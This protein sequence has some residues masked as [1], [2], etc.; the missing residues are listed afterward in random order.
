[1]VQRHEI[2]FEQLVELLSEASDQDY[3]LIHDSTD[4]L[5]K[6]IKVGL[7]RSRSTAP[8]GN[9]WH[10]GTTPPANPSE[11]DGWWRSNDDELLVWTGTT[12]KLIDE[13][14]RAGLA[15]V[16]T[17]D[18]VRQLLEAALDI[19][20]L[21]ISTG[22]VFR[23]TIAAQAT[24]TGPLL[25]LVTGDIDETIDGVRHQYTAP[26]ILYVPPLSTR[27]NTLF[28]REQLAA[29]V[30]AFVSQSGGEPADGSVTEAKLAQAVRDKLDHDIGLKPKNYYLGDV[31]DN[32]PFRV[33]QV[34]GTPGIVGTADLDG[35]YQLVLKNPSTMLTGAI[36]GAPERIDEL[37]IFITN[38]GISQR[39]HAVDPYTYSADTQVIDFNISDA[40][41]SSVVASITEPYV[42]FRISYYLSNGAV[43]TPATYRMPIEPQLETNTALVRR[44]QTGG[45]AGG[46]TFGS[47]SGEVATWAE[48]D[49]TANVPDSKISTAI[50]RKTAVDAVQV[51]A[52]TVIEIGPEF[53]HN[54]AGPRNLD[55]SIRH[56]LNAYRTANLMTVSVDGQPAVIV[57]YDHTVLAQSVMAEVSATVLMNVWNKQDRTV[58]PPHPQFYGVGS[59]IPVDIRLLTGVGGDTIFLRTVDILVVAAGS[60]FV[61]SKSNQFSAVK[62]IFHPDT[63]AGVTADDANNE[64]DVS[65][66][67]GGGSVST[68][69]DS[70]VGAD[71]F[72]FYKA[73]DG[74]L[75]RT[76]STMTQMIDRFRSGMSEATTS[77]K[78]LLSAALFNKLTALPTRAELTTEL[79]RLEA[80]GNLIVDDPTSPIAP[81][82]ANA[83]KILARGGR[84]Y[85][86]ILHS[87]TNPQVTYR[88]FIQADWRTAVGDN[89]AEWG[90]AVQVTSPANQ[91]PANYGL[92]SIPG[93]HFLRRFGSAFPANYTE[94]TPANWRGPAS[95]KD[96]A[97]ER[98]TAIGD[99]TYYDGAVRVVTAFVAGTTRHRTWEP[100]ESVP[101]DHS[102]TPDKVV[103][104]L[105][106]Q[107]GA[108]A[109]TPAGQ[110]RFFFTDEN[111]PG[112]PLSWIGWIPLVAAIRSAL[113]GLTHTQFDVDTVTKKRDFRAAFGSSAF[114]VGA[115]LPAGTATNAGDLH[116]FNVAVAS[117]LTWTDR[118]G[119]ALTSARQWDVGIYTGGRTWMR[120]A[121]LNDPLAHL[122]QL[123]SQVLAYSATLDMDVTLGYTGLLTLTGNCTFDITKAGR[124]GGTVGDV[125]ELIVTQDATGSRTLT[126]DSAI[127]RYHGVAA[128]VL[129]TDGNAIDHLLFK[130][131]TPT[132]WYY[133][134]QKRVS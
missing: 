61:P 102:V 38:G 73:A 45:G 99:I 6:R 47:G 101:A 95:S 49:S 42:E 25:A 134:G 8:S 130:L 4:G 29:I 98:V 36:A 82:D 67:G 127:R 59:Y 14:A 48:G 75:K 78:G 26:S 117:G 37:R 110:D 119:S 15:N 68:P 30:G 52:D 62:A 39:V 1:M 88:D 109:G 54:E 118:D 112:D 51:D 43:G 96:E 34:D 132:N 33:Y 71:R 89:N 32:L 64:L 21:Q 124:P 13:T 85:E 3:L 77:A 103:D 7:V 28:S 111:Q 113:S 27:V 133:I 86:N 53:I 106:R 125:A 63:N 57:D 2:Q 115:S 97:D 80:T 46:V 83:D 9:A 72:V 87:A 107:L 76:A 100:I 18:Q 16:P 41:E 108:R 92:Y 91:H 94:F 90:G 23:S 84:L 17:I 128:P 123:R 22:A 93:A 5:E 44:L 58:G 24:D 12:W 50:A 66:G 10:V 56:P 131:V 122:P 126:L 104:G 31:T 105:I 20:D 11:G 60:T 129:T 69:S 114:T 70:M 79:N 35:N 19:T 121:N 74:T 120:V 116:V 81:T 65:G 40:E 55:V